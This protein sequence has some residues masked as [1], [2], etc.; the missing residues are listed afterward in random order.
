MFM[1]PFP[2]AKLFKILIFVFLGLSQE[3]HKGL[4]RSGFGEGQKKDSGLERFTGCKSED[5]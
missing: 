4:Q 5:V 2:Y 3:F 1:A